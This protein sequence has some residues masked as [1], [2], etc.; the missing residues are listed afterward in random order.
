MTQETVEFLT[1][2]NIG[3]SDDPCKDVLAFTETSKILLFICRTYKLLIWIELIS[4]RLRL[5]ICVL[6]TGVGQNLVS[7]DVL[8]ATRL[9]N[10]RQSDTPEIQSA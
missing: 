3:K 6:E 10:V 2:K 9:D 4:L 5:I 7:A 1:K 8:D